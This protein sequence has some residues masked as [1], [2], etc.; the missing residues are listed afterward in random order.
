MDKYILILISCLFLSFIPVSGMK[1]PGLS[2][3]GISKEPK[4]PVSAIKDELKKDA[5]VVIREYSESIEIKS[6]TSIVIDVHRVITVLRE[7]GLENANLEVYYNQ[8]SKVNSIHAIC[9]NAEGYETEHSKSSM[10]LD[11]SAIPDGSFYSDDRVKRL[12]VI[13]IAYPFTMEYN[14]E[15]VLHKLLH[16]PAWIPQDDYRLSLEHSAFSL[17]AKDELLPRFKEFNLPNP[18]RVD[19]GKG[20]T[21]V[22][23][24]FENIPAIEAERY[25]IPIKERVPAVYI[26]PNDYRALGEDFDFRTWK[27][28]GMWIYNLN[29]DRDILPENTRKQ[30]MD[31]LK[32]KQ[33]KLEKI[34]ETY[35]FVQQNT[36]YLNTNIGIGGW[37]TIEASTIAEKGYGDC[38]GLVNY[39]RALM[40]AAGITSYY[41]LVGE[42]GEA[43]DVFVDFPS[44]QFNHVILCVPMENDTIWL[45]CTNQSIPFGYLGSTTTNRHVLLVTPDGGILVRTPKYEGSANTMNRKIIVGLDSTG[46]ASVGITARCRGLQYED[47]MGMENKSEQDLEKVLY[48]TII[49]P[50][51]TIKKINCSF[52]KDRDPEARVTINLSVRSFAS[53]TGNRI[54]LPFNAFTNINTSLNNLSNRKTPVFL[55]YSTIDSDTVEIHLPPGYKIESLPS[56]VEVSSQFGHYQLTTMQKDNVLTF[57][58]TIERKEGRYPPESFTEYTAYLQKIARADKS[59]AVLIKQ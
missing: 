28:Y 14:Y 16:Y 5:D 27:S 24:V 48:P 7:N 38:K 37:Q 58:R 46:N 35:H 1:C 47:V 51:A 8:D 53:R 13:G 29:R 18:A 42:G 57:F 11:E 34:K 59:N 4:Y 56:S 6:L 30:L 23:Y 25:S 45:E 2:A 33:T 44:N 19:H 41:A 49:M 15:I 3:S 43:Q 21:A 10:I 20:E 17:V 52:K 26:A 36:R 31:V 12:K 9:Y 32:D 50:S 22:S 39:T 54:F 55:R 40:S